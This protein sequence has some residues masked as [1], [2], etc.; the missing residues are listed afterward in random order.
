MTILLPGI[1]IPSEAVLS[2]ERAESIDSTTLIIS[3][4]WSVPTFSAKVEWQWPARVLCIMH[5]LEGT[6]V[7]HW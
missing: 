4:L 6:L 1:T 3:N 7:I 5:K 2:K